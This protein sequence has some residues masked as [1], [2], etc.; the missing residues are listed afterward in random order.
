MSTPCEEIRPELEALLG[1]MTEGKLDA[2]GRARLSSVLREH[3]DAR[4]FYLDYCQMHALLV[5]AHGLLRALEDPSSTRRTRWAWIGAAAA[6]LVLVMG[7]LLFRQAPRPEA[8]V[9]SVRGS[10]WAIRDGQRVSLSEHGA[11]RGG[12]RV[13]TDADSR[14]EIKTQDGSKVILLDRSEIR[15]EADRLELK[16]G[17]LRCAI[18]PQP[19]ARPLAFVTPHAEATVLGTSFELAVEGGETRLHTLEGRVR[20][21][22]EGQSV[23]VGPGEKAVAR[24]G[25]IVRW[26]PVCDLDFSKTRTLP[27]QLEPVFC[28]SKLLHTPERKV[29]SAPERI[30]FVEGGLVLGATPG[31]KVEH[32]LVVARWKEEVGDD[33]ILEADLAGGER[34]SLGFAVSG[35]SFEGYRIIF[36]VPGYPA[37]ISVDTIH[38]VECIVLAADPRLIAYE[39]DHLLR[40]EKCGKRVKVWVDR[41]LRIDTEIAHALPDGRRRSFAISNFGAPPVIRALRAWKAAP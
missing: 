18:A 8:S 29:D 28:L 14:T 5:S 22:S 34:W 30:H 23:E 41:E 33:V 3:P 10:A 16:N 25:K 36:A 11:I 7:A 2:A 31:L 38:P 15:I 37:G 13:V 20:F 27:S 24:S 26:T 32:G 35:D 17:T 12:D 40:V 21:T 9:A 1:A 39:K 19:A 6:I 4:Q